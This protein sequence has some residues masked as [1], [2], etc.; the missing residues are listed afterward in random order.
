M[1]NKL[2]LFTLS[3]FFLA[4]PSPDV[5]DDG[6]KNNFQVKKFFEEFNKTEFISGIQ[7]KRQNVQ[8]YVSEIKDKDVVNGNIKS[9]YSDVQNAYNNILLQ[10]NADVDAIDN[11]I[12]FSTLNATN[13][14]QD[15]LKDAE[16]K[17]TIFINTATKLLFPKEETSF[18]G[19][20]FNNLLSLIPGA[21]KIQDI[22]L[23]KLKTDIKNKINAAK[24]SDWENI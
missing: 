4:C 23:S 11:I 14:Y 24:W 17:E 1:K 2:T 10:M 16:A 22:Y 3:L 8:E 15:A 21:R 20:L 13:R 18:I 5:L 12:D 6:Y 19:D 7:N 9:L